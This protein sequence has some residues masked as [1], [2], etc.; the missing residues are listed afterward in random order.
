[1]LARRTNLLS[2]PIARMGDDLPVRPARPLAAA[3]PAPAAEPPAAGPAVEPPAAAPAVEP[4]ATVAAPRAPLDPGPPPRIEWL[5][6]DGLVIDERYQRDV[7]GRASQ[8]LIRRIAAGWRWALFQPL[9][10]A[11]SSL[12]RPDDGT[13]WEGRPV[14][15][16]IDGQHRLEAARRCGFERLPCYIID[17]ASVELQ[18]ASFIALNRDRRAMLPTQLHRAAVVAGDADAVQIERVCGLAGVT[19]ARTGRPEGLPPG[20]TLAVQKIRFCIARYGEKIAADALRLVREAAGP[21]RDQL[22]AEIIAGVAWLLSRRD[23]CPPLGFDE[24]TFR[25]V[26]GQ[27]QAQDWLHKARERKRSAG[28]ST[29]EAFAELF[30]RAYRKAATG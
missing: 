1:M 22:R 5:P 29:V 10:V 9:T 8:T 11:E 6:V 28:G 24:A 15:A 12:A 16:V 20:Q 3:A 26:L 14:H 30:A 23:W 25:R 19:V 13:P 17:A 2:A 4:P 27:Q 18:A 7:S 21:T